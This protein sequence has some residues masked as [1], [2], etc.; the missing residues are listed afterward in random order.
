MRLHTQ[1]RWFVDCMRRSRS[2]FAPTCR[3][4]LSVSYLQPSS[5]QEHISLRRG[6][7]ARCIIEDGP[8]ATCVFVNPTNL[9]QGRRCISFSVSTSTEYTLSTRSYEMRRSETRVL[10]RRL[11]VLQASYEGSP[12]FQ[13]G[14]PS[15][16][17]LESRVAFQ[18]LT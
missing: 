3:E 8:A 16:R 10:F 11:S 9:M 5:Q 18:E 1:Q 6:P 12:V 13:T 2:S 14:I 17:S 4:E 15:Y 7:C